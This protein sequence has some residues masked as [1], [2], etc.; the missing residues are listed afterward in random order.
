MNI[1]QKGSVNVVLVVVIV[2]FVGIVGYLVF[3]KKSE[4]IAQQTA[5]TPTQ[6]APTP[7]PV[8]TPTP[9]PSPIPTTTNPTANLKTYLVSGNNGYEFEYPQGGTL[10]TGDE[11]QNKILN[12]SGYWDARGGITEVAVL[13]SQSTFS[14]GRNGKITTLAECKKVT[15]PSDQKVELTTTKVINGITYYFGTYQGVAAGTSTRFNVYHAFGGSGGDGCFELVVSVSPWDG[16]TK[17][18][19]QI[20][21]TFKFTK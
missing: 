13:S 9:A 15:W 10:V 3:P 2:I 6:Q 8:V 12:A 16:S 18:S 4:P 14:V 21:S 17:A 20:L 19:D 1:N 5:P 7:T 11:L